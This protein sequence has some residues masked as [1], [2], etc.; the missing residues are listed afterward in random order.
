VINVFVFML[1]TG[2]TQ[3][4]TFKGNFGWD[5]LG[6]LDIFKYN[7]LILTAYIGVFFVA[8]DSLLAIKIGYVTIYAYYIIAFTDLMYSGPRRFWKSDTIASPIC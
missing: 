1:Q 2:T 4:W 8:F 3:Y 5:I 7:F 6:Y